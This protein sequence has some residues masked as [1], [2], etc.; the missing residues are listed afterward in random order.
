MD[1]LIVR[2]RQM[3]RQGNVQTGNCA[4]GGCSQNAILNAAVRTHPQT[5]QSGCIIN[6]VTLL[7]HEDPEATTSSNK[8]RV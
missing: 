3:C 2:H 8:M 6:E 7:K 4:E 1:E 5:L